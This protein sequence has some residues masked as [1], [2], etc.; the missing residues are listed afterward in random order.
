MRVRERSR[1]PVI[2]SSIR[3]VPHR[4]PFPDLLLTS[5]FAPRRT[6]IAINVT[7]EGTIQFDETSE[8]HI[9]THTYARLKECTHTR[10]AD[11]RTSRSHDYGNTRVCSRVVIERNSDLFCLMLRCSS[12]SRYDRQF[13]RTPFQVSAF[14]TGT[15]L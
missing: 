10:C 4:H 15:E 14:L 3:K 6:A 11:P 2:N 5:S 9:N 1:D 7:Y 8:R 13:C 12:F